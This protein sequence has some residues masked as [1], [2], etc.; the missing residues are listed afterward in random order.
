MGDD[1]GGGD[2]DGDGD[3]DGNGVR[4]YLDGEGG[5]LVDKIEAIC[6]LGG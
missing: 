4:V 1:V 3:G 2:G 6:L 5:C